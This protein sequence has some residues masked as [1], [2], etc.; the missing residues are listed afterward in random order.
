MNSRSPVTEPGRKERMK[1]DLVVVVAQ[2]GLYMY[3]HGSL[4][5]RGVIFVQYVVFSFFVTLGRITCL[6]HVL[7]LRSVS[8]LIC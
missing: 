7:E 2:A 4:S 8:C 6:V 1:D 3:V 5:K